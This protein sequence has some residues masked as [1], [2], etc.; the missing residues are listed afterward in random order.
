MNLLPLVVVFLFVIAF[1]GCS[2]SEAR[3][4]AEPDW[5]TAARKRIEQHRMGTFTVRVTDAD[6]APVANVPVQ[7]VMR[8]H[9]FRFG[10]A[11]SAAHLATTE[12][13]DPYRERFVELFNHAPIEN[14][15]KWYKQDT[16]EGC[17]EADAAVQW[18]NEQRIS[19]HAHCMV[20]A[21][22]NLHAL[23]RDVKR[24]FRDEEMPLGQKADYIRPRVLEHIA[25][26]GRRYA[27]RVDEWD[28]INEQHAQHVLTE[29]L[30]PDAPAAE[31]PAQVDWFVAARE[32]DPGAR[33][34]VNDY[35]ILVGDSEGHKASYEKQIAYLLEQGTPL[36]GIGM[37]GHYYKGDLRRTPAQLL[38]TLERFARFGIPIQVTEFDTYGEGWGDT[39]EEVE[40]AQA[41]FMRTFYTVCFSHPAVNGI[42]MWGFWDGRHWGKCAPLFRKDWTAKPGLDVY[43]DLVFGEW[44][45]EREGATDEGG[46][47]TFRGFYGDYEVVLPCACPAAVTFT[48]DGQEEVLGAA[49]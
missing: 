28:V 2:L 35:G 44:W 23:P 49:P 4:S 41:E 47:F 5:L 45:T 33:L 40:A 37:Q 18:L 32:A 36:G 25:D 31:A 39:T 42:T 3:P 20:W 12:P 6:G 38:A 13:G 15:L 21:I 26:V 30:N 34:Y 43:R 7:V 9:A 1:S 17:A 24:V 48:R 8:R 11:L 22:K 27:G 16:P 10:S 19:I 29:V 14:A 46:R